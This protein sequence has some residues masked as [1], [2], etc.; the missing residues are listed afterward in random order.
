MCFK[1]AHTN[2]LDIL[3]VYFKIFKEN[4]INSARKKEIYLVR[5]N[6][7]SNEITGY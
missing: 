4:T 1:E 7:L 6:I 5:F 2:Y 3:N